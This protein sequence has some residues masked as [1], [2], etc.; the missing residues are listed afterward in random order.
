LSALDVFEGVPLHYQRADVWLEPLDRRA[1]QAALVYRAQRRWIVEDGTPSPGYLELL[2]RGARQHGLA[3]EYI[4]W[5][6]RRA[7]GEIE[8]CYAV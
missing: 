1:R 8:E 4:F 3:E 7:R 6:Q 2:I 5:L